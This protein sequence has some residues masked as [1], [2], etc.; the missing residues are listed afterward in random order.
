[1]AAFEF[2]YFAAR[3]SAQAF[4]MSLRFTV[5]GIASFIGSA[6][7]TIFLNT[8][9]LLDFSECKND[10]RLRWRF[11]TYLFVLAALQLIFILIFILCQK[12]ILLVKLSLQ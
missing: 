4:F 9:I 2:A 1:V 5:V 6:Y 11:Y 8:T 3:R 10:Q 12:R 7:M